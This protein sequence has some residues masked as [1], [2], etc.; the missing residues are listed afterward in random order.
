MIIKIVWYW[1]KVKQINQ[2]NIIDIQRYIYTN[3]DTAFDKGTKAVQWRKDR[4][5]TNGPGTLM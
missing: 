4:F 3:M 2:W 1:R 5:S